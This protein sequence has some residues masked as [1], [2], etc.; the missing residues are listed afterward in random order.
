MKFLIERLPRF[1]KL[2]LNKQ[3]RKLSQQK[4]SELKSKVEEVTNSLK[5]QF[6]SL[7]KK[8][9]S[10]A[11]RQGYEAAKSELTTTIEHVYKSVDVDTEIDQMLVQDSTIPIPNALKLPFVES[12]KS[13][14]GYGPIPE[15]QDLIFATGRNTLANAGAGSG[16]STTLIYRVLFM[17]KELNYS[18]ESFTIF[19]FTAASVQEFRER[20][21]EVFAAHG[22]E[23]KE[24]TAKTVVRTFHS[25]VLEMSK[26]ALLNGDESIF[27]FISDCEA[28]DT[29]D[30][31]RIG[32]N[33]ERAVEITDDEMVL[34]T[35]LSMIQMDF[36]YQA[37]DFAWETEP[38]FRQLML[39]IAECAL[40]AEL[41]SNLKKPNRQTARLLSQKDK[42]IHAITQTLYQIDSRITQQRD[43]NVEV[44]ISG[45]TFKLKSDLYLPD[46]DVHVL[47]AASK[48]ELKSVATSMEAEPKIIDFISYNIAQKAHLLSHYT[49][50]QNKVYV[51]RSHLEASLLEHLVLHQLGLTVSQAK[52]PR[53]EV[54]LGGEFESTLLPEAFYQLAS[55]IESLGLS[56]SD[57]ADVLSGAKV[58]KIDRNFAEALAILWPI[59][60]QQILGKKNIVRFSHMF[61]AFSHAD[62]TAFDELRVSVKGSLENIIIDEFQDIS[63]QIADWIRGTLLR[64]KQEMR[65]TT[66]MCVGDDYQSIYGWRGSSP[67][68]I[69]NYATAFPSKDT[70]LVRMDTNFRSYQ[71]IVSIAESALTYPMLERKNGKSFLNSNGRAITSFIEIPENDFLNHLEKQVVRFIQSY[72]MNDNSKKAELLIMSKTN[73]VLKKVKKQLAFLPKKFPGLRVS[74][75]T[76]HR[77]KGLE[78]SYCILVE[79]CSY[80]S[81]NPLKNHLYKLAGFKTNFDKAQEAESKRLAYV[82]MTRAKYGFAWFV[83]EEIKY[84]GSFKEVKT[85]WCSQRA[86]IPSPASEYYP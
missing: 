5:K 55:F 32:V 48:E 18:L 27:E 37:I 68:F 50:Q 36:I 6:S 57:A 31:N 56:L 21:I 72:V 54:K 33:L 69:E 65:T 30:N 12:I 63:P 78:S 70:R 35:K 83:K 61:S 23:V 38:R 41:R 62:N 24:S 53:F 39:T 49:T 7:L 64:L 67:E 82:A 20:L 74:Y 58:D 81:V 1:S 14:S 9:K 25:K 26:G 71:E 13:I 46:I 66:L 8:E 84:P 76:F 40:Q 22:I 73:K 17:V 2:D 75:Q 79:D 10:E 77:S 34:V 85:K 28:K 29:E 11:Y 42:Q 4:E 44:T 52:C 51:V 43:Q 3:E 60:D 86:Q 59:L 45:Q 19:S 47:F 80:S 15:Q 16:K